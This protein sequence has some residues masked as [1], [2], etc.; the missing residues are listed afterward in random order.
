MTFFFFFLI[1][2]SAFL[3]AAKSMVTGHE[4]FNFL[5][6]NNYY[7]FKSGLLARFTRHRYRV[8]PVYRVSRRAAPDGPELE[9]E[10]RMCFCGTT[11]DVKHI[12]IAGNIDCVTTTHG[13]LTA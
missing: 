9:H 1:L 8:A 7:Y 6:E 11:R 12:I 10:P 2:L 4:W 3:L 13:T 5:L